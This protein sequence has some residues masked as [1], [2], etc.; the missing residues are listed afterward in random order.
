MDYEDVIPTNGFESAHQNGTHGQF[1][2]NG[3]AA[4]AVSNANVV[5]ETADLVA[6][7]A[8]LHE[9]KLDGSGNDKNI[10]TGCA[11]EIDGSKTHMVD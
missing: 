6:V 11:R 9:F 4:I 3:E 7:E 2:N 1:L 5:A 10:S 8:N